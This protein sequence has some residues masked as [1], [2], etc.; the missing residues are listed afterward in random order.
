MK[1]KSFKTPVI[2]SWKYAG[3]CMSPKGTLMYSYFPNG[4]VNAVLGIEDSSKGIWWYPA[5]RS[6]VEKYFAPFNWGKISLAWAK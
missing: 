2:S 5:H 1:E 3:A 4:E 6:N